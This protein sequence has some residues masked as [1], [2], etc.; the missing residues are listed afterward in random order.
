MVKI[1]KNKSYSVHSFF[2]D[3]TEQP[4]YMVNQHSG[5]KMFFFF[6]PVHYHKSVGT[7]G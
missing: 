3:E 7:T 5:K 1:D 6:D 4:M 2:S